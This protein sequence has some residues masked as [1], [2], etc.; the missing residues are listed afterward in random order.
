MINKGEMRLDMFLV[1]YHSIQSRN[2]ARELIKGGFIQV[3]GRIVTKPSFEVYPNDE[4]KILKKEIFVSRAGEKLS[5]YIRD[6]NL[7]FCGM[8]ILDIGSSKGGFT[9]VL[10]QYGAK[11]VTCVDVGINQ[12]DRTL[13]ENPRVTLFESCD[14]RDYKSDREF[15]FV[16]C[17]VSFIS[18]QKI[19]DCIYSLTKSQALLLFKPQFEVGILPKRNKKG[20]VLH[21][22][23]ITKSFHSLLECIKAHNFDIIHTQYSKIKG[24]EGNEEIFINIQK[25]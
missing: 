2:K 23:S 12:L 3:G 7:C 15:D 20:V 10:L 4:V 22:D 1:Q 16:V 5:C 17:D 18:L 25:R 19:I 9:Q 14:I 6:N 13:R 11:S 8:D 24:K 21:K